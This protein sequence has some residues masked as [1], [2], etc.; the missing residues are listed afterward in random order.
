MLVQ[1]NARKLQP[2]TSDISLPPA[3]T[4]PRYAESPRTLPPSQAQH[5]PTQPCLARPWPPACHRLAAAATTTTSAHAFPLLQKLTEH[6]GQ[7]L[8]GKQNA[9]LALARGLKTSAT[10]TSTSS[11]SPWPSTTP[12]AGSDPPPEDSW[13]P[14]P[15]GAQGLRP[16]QTLDPSLTG[17]VV[18]CALQTPRRAR[19]QR[20][21]N[22]TPATGAHDWHR[23][24]GP[25]AALPATAPA[26]GGAELS[27]LPSSFSRSLSSCLSSPTSPPPNTGAGAAPPS[28][29][30]NAHVPTPRATSSQAAAA[31]P[32]PS[33]QD[34]GSPGSAK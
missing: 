6:V 7:R 15:L 30:S 34:K 21:H 14:L 12:S 16:S 33:L 3:A 9:M 27:P 20:K 29:T 13:T 32:R 11:S 2:R 22:E 31:T 4:A 8:S 17:H 10:D 19:R 1:G 5:P 28:N 26:A 23:S 18:F 24:Q 25:N